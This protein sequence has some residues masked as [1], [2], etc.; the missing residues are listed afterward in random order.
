MLLQKQHYQLVWWRNAGDLVNWR[1][2][3]DVT[4]L[5]AL[6]MERPEVFM[7]THAY[8]FDLYKRGLIDGLRI[9]HVDGLLQPTEYCQNLKKELENLNKKR[10]EH[11]RSNS[12]IFVEKILA[13]NETLLKKMASFWYHRV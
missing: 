12:I 11:L 8:I 10:P 9:D 13:D 7:R 4:S 5:V 1:R 3:F 2:F 6:R